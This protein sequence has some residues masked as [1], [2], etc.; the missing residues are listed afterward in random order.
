MLLNIRNLL[1]GAVLAPLAGQQSPRVCLPSQAPG[2]LRSHTHCPTSA[3]TLVPRSLTHVLMH[4]WQA[5]RPALRAHS[6]C[7]DLSI[8][9]ERDDA[10]KCQVDETQMFGPKATFFADLLL[11]CRWWGCAG[12][13]CVCAWCVGG[14]N[15][16]GVLWCCVLWCCVCV[17]GVYVCVWYVGMS[18]CVWCAMVLC[19][20]GVYV[21]VWCVGKSVCVFGMLWY[22]MCMVFM[23]ECVCVCVVCECVCV[24]GIC[25]CIWYVCI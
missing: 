19:L 5:P 22:C 17:C 7:E 14:V 18:E 13:W 12:V 10:E 6:L 23:Y 1:D 11:G 20:C 16:Y 2:V 21:C 9:T 25:E 3:L 4:T 15:V 24:Y 8:R